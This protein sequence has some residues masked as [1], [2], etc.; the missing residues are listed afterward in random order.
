M[1]VRI[2]P[3]YGVKETLVNQTSDPASLTTWNEYGTQVSVNRYPSEEFTIQVV[4]YLMG[5]QGPR[6]DA[7]EVFQHTQDIASSLWTVNHNKGYRPNATVY[8]AGWLEVSA[9]I[10]HV[11]DNQLTVEFNT[12]QTGFVLC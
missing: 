10:V 2:W 9:R 4:P 3:E 1:T 5:A 11:S 8:T 7:A 12:P 6:G